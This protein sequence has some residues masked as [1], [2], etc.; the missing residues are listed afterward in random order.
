[1]LGRRWMG[2]CVAMA[3]AAVLAVS[4]QQGPDPQVRARMDAFV[5]ALASGD[6]D[7]YEAMARENFSPDYLAARSPAQRRQFL[8][9]LR[10]DFGRPTI[11]RIRTDDGETFSLAVS[12]S[13]GL[14]GEIVLRLEAASPRRIAAISV[15][16]GE[17][18]GGDAGALAPPPVRKDMGAADLA[19]ALD[20]YLS[21][22]SAA[23]TFAGAVLVARDGSPVYQRAFGEANRET[24]AFRRVQEEVLHLGRLVDDLQELALAEARELRLVVGTVDLGA[25]I[26]SAA[27][28]AGLQPGARLRL[29]VAAGATAKGE[30]ARVRQVV[31]NLLTNADRYAPPE[32]AVLVRCGAT[33]DEAIVEVENEGSR[34]DDDQ[35]RRLFDRFYRTDP[36]RQ[37]VTGGSGLGL[38]IVKH[39]V[40]AQGGRVWARSS[41]ASVI[42]GFSLPKTDSGTLSA[43]GPLQ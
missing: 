14:K 35:L 3:S 19:Q 6:A 10:T 17:P 9:R 36:S 28:A 7:R 5:S 15:E 25:V 26:R 11:G 32:A 38:A 34:L 40:E 27:A 42:V 20:A 41:E 8:E 33:E 16:V 43:D 39:L 24:Q 4:A 13:T 2:M 30:A 1:M 12:G 22:L 21:P 29:E 31:L 23:D 18:E 37:R